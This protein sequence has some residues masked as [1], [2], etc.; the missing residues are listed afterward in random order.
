[1]VN[2]GRPTGDSLAGLERSIRRRWVKLKGG[3]MKKTFIIIA[4]LVIALVAYNTGFHTANRQARQECI[5]KVSENC[6]FICGVGAEFYYPDKHGPRSDDEYELVDDSLVAQ[7]V[8]R[9]YGLR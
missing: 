6:E 2:Y 1:M 5:D 9:K 7:K 8:D 3:S 4:F